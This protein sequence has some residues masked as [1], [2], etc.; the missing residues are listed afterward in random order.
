MTDNNLHL[1]QWK[2]V[3]DRYKYMIDAGFTKYLPKE[4]LQYRIECIDELLNQEE[5]KE[6]PSHFK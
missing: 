3:R 1:K 6:N 4:A 5:I 2:T